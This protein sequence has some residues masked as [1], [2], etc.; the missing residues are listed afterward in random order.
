MLFEAIIG[1]HPIEDVGALRPLEIFQRIL[2]DGL[3]A[4]RDI[5]KD[6][7][8]AL[9][10]LCR[11]MLEKNAPARMQTLQTFVDELTQYLKYQGK[12]IAGFGTFSQLSKPKEESTQAIESRET[13]VLKTTV[14]DQHETNRLQKR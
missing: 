12:T 10:N 2:R 3:P 6:V 4:P 5:S 7:P 14:I 13:L 1:R 9:D 8:E 11:R